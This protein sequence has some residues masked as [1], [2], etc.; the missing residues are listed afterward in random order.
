MPDWEHR[1]W[2]DRDNLF[3]IEKALPDCVDD[4][5]KFPD[6]VIRADVARYLY[7]YEFGGVY[8]DTDYRFFRSPN[9]DLLSHICILGVEAEDAPEVG[10]GPKLGNAFIASQPGL[11]SVARFYL[12]R[13]YEISKW[14]DPQRFRI[15]ERSSCVDPFSQEQ[16]RL[17]EH[18]YH[19]TARSDLPLIGKI[20]FNRSS[21][22]RDYRGSFMLVIVAVYVIATSGQK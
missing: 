22:C 7:M 13:V 14:R 20:Q 21:Q 18:G 12:Q 11:N 5:L 16:Q 4:Y 2:S 10:G 9:E 1:F 8:F 3:L 19:P 6:G 15:F 17:R